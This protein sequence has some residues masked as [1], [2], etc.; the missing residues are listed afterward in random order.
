MTEHNERDFFA[1]TALQRWT[2]CINLLGLN[3]HVS[4]QGVDHPY[5]TKCNFQLP[6]E[7]TYSG[8]D[9]GYQQQSELNPKH[10]ALEVLLF[11]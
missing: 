5:T 11:E 10:E 1:D 8:L 7:K 4:Q 6:L 2:E 3:H 9:K